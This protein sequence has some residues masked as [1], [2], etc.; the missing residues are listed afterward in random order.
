MLVIMNFDKVITAVCGATKSKQKNI[1]HTWDGWTSCGVLHI[2]SRSGAS[3]RTIWHFD[4]N[5]NIGKRLMFKNTASSAYVYVR[6]GA[7]NELEEEALAM[8]PHCRFE[9]QTT[10]NVE[11][12][13]HASGLPCIDNSMMWFVI[14]TDG[15]IK[16]AKKAEIVRRTVNNKR[17][18]EYRIGPDTVH[19]TGGT[20]A[21]QGDV[22][23]SQALIEPIRVVITLQADLT[24]IIKILRSAYL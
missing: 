7:Q 4:I 20:Y 18:T 13:T 10:L 12:Q 6:P 17:H 8:N 22:G 1:F 5:E 16:T 9:Q 3:S 23:Q 11:M 19:I 21:I 2:V 14:L 15:N 24:N